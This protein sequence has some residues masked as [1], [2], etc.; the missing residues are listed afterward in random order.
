MGYTLQ[1]RHRTITIL[2][3]TSACIIIGKLG[4]SASS[5]PTAE[6]TGP[7][8]CK[9][10]IWPLYSEKR[11]T[12]VRAV[13]K[14]ARSASAPGPNGIPYKLYKNCPQVLKCLWK[15]MSVAW[16]SQLIP[17]EWQRAVAVFI[18]KEQESHNISQF[19]SIALLNVEGK[20]FFA[21][22][23]KRLTSYLIENG[24]IDTSCQKAGVPGFP[25]CVEHSS[26]I[27]GQIQRAKQEKSN[28][29][30]VWLD[31]ANAYGSVPHKLIQF[32]LEFFHVPEAIT[33]LVSSYFSDFQMCFSLQEFTTGWQQLEVGIAMGCSI[34]PVLFV[35]AFEIILRGARQ[36]V[37]GIRL[38]TGQRLP[39]LR[40]YMDDVTVVLETA[41]CTRRCLKRMDELVTWARMKIK[42]SKSRSLSLRK[43]IRNDNTIFVAGGEQIPL[44]AN[45]PIQS[46]GRQYD[47]DLSDKHA[48]KAV[49]KQLSE[50]LA[51]INKSQLPGKYK[52]WCYNF[53]LYQ[54][55]MWP[56]KMCDIPSS[57]ANGLDRL[58]NSY[59][60]KW[61]GLP[62]CFSD[63]GLFGA[64]SLQL[65]I[66]SITLG[67]KQE[68]ARLVLELKESSDPTVRNALVPTRTGR[69][70]QADPEVAKAIGRLQ[71]QEIVGR[72][73]VG[74]A[75]LGWGDSPR[76]W[77]KATKR[78]RKAMIVE[79]VSKAN[80]EQYTI[81]AVSQGRQ[82]RWTTW[83]GTLKRPI[84]WADLWKM[85]Q[86]R[87]SFLLR[88]TYDTL[89]CPRNLHQWFGKEE[90]CPLCSAPNA[91]LQ[92]LMS[93]CKCALTQGRY[94][95]RHDQVLTKLAEVLESCR[96]DA[97]NQPLAR[98]L[99]VKFVRPGEGRGDTSRRGPRSVL[100]LA[101]DWSMRADIGKQLQFPREITTTSLRPDI[102]LWSA[103]AKSAMLIELTIPWEEGIQAA[104]ERK[105]AKYADL[106]AECR[107]AGWSTT[108]YPVEVGC[109]GFVGTSTTRLLRDVGTTGAK[110]RRVTKAL[111]EEAEKGSFWLWLRRRD[112]NWGSRQ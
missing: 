90:S 44:L 79:E 53:T 28:L 25:G 81:K 56:L 12:E 43:G 105:A 100:S 9:R 31:L 50:G 99:P 88:A 74:R 19:R 78:E 69:K 112:K 86:A 22:M 103:A 42:P 94:G 11:V 40:S 83:E 71:H 17:S 61:L 111:A 102:V 92:H 23:A 54:R 64:N 27:W 80:Q 96:Q 47:A 14:K 15:L 3:L 48:G 98:Q 85:P 76:L 107:E 38:Q 95:W 60:R 46:L 63:T 52:L 70:W 97:N 82:G 21:V 33:N 10:D 62:R 91:S 106:A 58:A 72:A 109:R 7:C 45:Q 18:P 6:N 65:P 87:L 73:Q 68:K 110:L 30:V 59:I 55:V 1:W 84:S 77:S 67:Y 39:P 8:L 34:S 108:I 13:V 93:G 36:T 66:Q 41:P 16:K 20:V 37:G 32:A 4:K 75:G 51:S 24:Y 89:P 57:T 5:T 26:M 101:R 29:H 2:L 35:A 49:R 104:Y